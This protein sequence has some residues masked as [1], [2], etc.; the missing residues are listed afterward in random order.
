M[1]LFNAVVQAGK[2]ER[3]YDLVQRLHSERALDVAITLVVDSNL[4]KYTDNT[5]LLL[6]HK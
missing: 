2:V 3:A 4:D 6:Y 5:I 1:K